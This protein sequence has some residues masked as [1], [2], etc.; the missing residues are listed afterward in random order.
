MFIAWL[1]IRCCLKK[2]IFR[3]FLSACVDQEVKA[4]KTPVDFILISQDVWEKYIVDSLHAHYAVIFER[5][6][7]SWV[8][9]NYLDERWEKEGSHLSHVF[10][11]SL[12]HIADYQ[13]LFMSKHL[14]LPDLPQKL[15]AD[16]WENKEICWGDGILR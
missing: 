2:I 13:E 15:F 8:Q 5:A 7:T 14:L 6:C 12:F 16:M 4:W 1:K 9:D 3:I 11:L 10:Y